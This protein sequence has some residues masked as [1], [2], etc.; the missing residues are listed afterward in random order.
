MSA[1]LHCCAELQISAISTLPLPRSLTAGIMAPHSHLGWLPEELLAEIARR[2]ESSEHLDWKMRL[3]TERPTLR[4]LSLVSR[5][6]RRISQENASNVTVVL[7][8]FCKDTVRKFKAKARSFPRGDDLKLCCGQRGFAHR[9]AL[10]ILQEYPG[11]RSLR[12]RFHSLLP[13]DRLW[14]FPKALAGLRL[15]ECLQ[16]RGIWNLVF[17]PEETGQWTSLQYLDLQGCANLRKLPP[18]ACFMWKNLRHLVLNGCTGLRK[19][20]KSVGEWAMLESIDLSFLEDLVSLPDSIG[21]WQKLRVCNLKKCIRLEELPQTVQAWVELR[22]MLMRGCRS[23]EGFSCAVRKW[24][25]LETLDVGKCVMLVDLPV[26]VANW[27]QISSVSFRKSYRLRELSSCVKGWVGLRVLDLSFSNHFLRGLPEEV[28]SWF[29]L[30][31]LNLSDC[32]GLESLPTGVESWSGLRKVSFVRCEQLKGLPEAVRGWHGLKEIDLSSCSS[33]ESL[34]DG[35]YNWIQIETVTL[36]YCENL[37][38][39]SKDRRMGEPP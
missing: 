17:L 24:T 28:A 4:D 33:L 31:E 23:F 9:V 37:V 5:Q 16:A 11:L 39:L 25:K 2:V 12:L 36:D 18:D 13:Q 20:P 3:D 10:A 29:L 34:P 8:D 27:I 30:E 6:W 21:N 32:W 15:L 1:T 35:V 19:L 14:A 22:H 7:G 38:G 26:D